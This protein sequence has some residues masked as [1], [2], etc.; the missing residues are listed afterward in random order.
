VKKIDYYFDFLSPFS[1]FSLINLEKINFFEQY[2]VTLKPV[3]M[4]SLFNHFEMKGPGEILP[5]RQYMLK[6]CFIYSAQNNIPFNPP[7]KHPFNPL[8]ALRLATKACSEERQ[9][10]MTKLLFTSVWENGLTLGEPEDLEPI[11]NGHNFNAKELIDKTFE[12]EVKKEL[13]QNTKDA[14]EANV[15]GVPSFVVNDNLF[16][17]ND[18]IPDLLTFLKG[19]F[20]KWNKNLYESKIAQDTTDI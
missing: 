18:S 17:G 8:Y 6:Q 11:L 7:S 12:R 19:D 9:L 16:W 4:G 14:I 1:Y 3:V 5:K 2:D 15:F 20:V 13:K 10:E